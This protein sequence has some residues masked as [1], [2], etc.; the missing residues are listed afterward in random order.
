MFKNLN[1]YR[2]KLCKHLKSLRFQ[3]NGST[4]ILDTLEEGG[5]NVT[6][7]GL[8]IREH[9]DVLEWGMSYYAIN[10]LKSN[11]FHKIKTPAE[12][13]EEGTACLVDFM[14]DFNKELLIRENQ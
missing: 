8:L 4:P 5:V 13:L 7:L 6:Q 11:T 1:R 10:K 14:R 2:K 3:R 9:G 12:G